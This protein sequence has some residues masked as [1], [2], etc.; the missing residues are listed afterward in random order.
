MSSYPRLCKENSNYQEGKRVPQNTT[1]TFK[2]IWQEASVKTHVQPSRGNVGLGG[3][4]WPRLCVHNSFWPGSPP[5]PFHIYF[6]WLLEL[7]LAFCGCSWE[8][9]GLAGNI[10]ALKLLEL[11]SLKSEIVHNRT[12]RISLSSSSFDL[13]GFL[14]LTPSFEIPRFVADFSPCHRP[15]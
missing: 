14:N 2:A 11:G 4:P 6:Y 9:R 1:N 5:T 8:S 3:M 12:Q 10:R 15:H 7:S 13:I